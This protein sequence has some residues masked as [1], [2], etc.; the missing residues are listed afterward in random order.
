MIQTGAFVCEDEWVGGGFEMWH[1]GSRCVTKVYLYL[2]GT[3]EHIRLRDTGKVRAK[4]V[5]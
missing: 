5:W 4:R 3:T 1:G 2:R